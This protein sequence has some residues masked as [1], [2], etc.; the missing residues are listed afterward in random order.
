[1]VDSEIVMGKLSKK[2]EMG[3]KLIDGVETP[4]RFAELISSKLIARE[5]YG[6]KR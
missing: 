3:E 4:K 5:S 6:Q 1:M 2:E